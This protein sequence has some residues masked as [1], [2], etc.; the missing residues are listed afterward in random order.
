M[1][2]LQHIAWGLPDGSEIIKDV[3]LEI[4]DNRMVVVTGPNGGG[5]TTLAKLIAGLETPRTGRIIFD[6]E[7][8]TQVDVTGRAKMGLAYAF[9]QPV[10]F[11]G[12]TV[13]DML[14]LAAGGKLTEDQ[15]CSL[16]GKVGLCASEYIGRELNAGL[17]GG[18]IKRIE[19]ATVLARNAK[20]MIFDEPEAGIDLW[21]FARL[22]E[23]F[24]EIRRKESGTLLI[25]SHQERLL[26]IADEILVIA[27]GMVRDFGPR[28][29]VLPALLADEK[30]VRCPLG[31]E[32]AAV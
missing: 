31:K 6:G 5:K 20:L 24:Q 8:I 27:G 32:M 23:T 14:E 18:E 7:D 11:K 12:I 25:I 22:A 1:L 19:I 3:D 2:K 16:L 15:L 10:R 17:S 28:E 29:R 26:S 21:S 30:A 13:Q 9:Q 4:P